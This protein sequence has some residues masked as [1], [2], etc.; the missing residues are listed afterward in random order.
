[1]LFAVQEFTSCGG[2]NLHK[3]QI[4]QFISTTN[5]RKAKFKLRYLHILTIDKTTKGFE[6]YDEK[7]AK[8]AIRE[9]NMAY[10][11]LKMITFKS[12]CF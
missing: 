5:M 8:S 9:R 7:D 11:L 3:N 2:K 4:S 1:V 10:S 6:C 12:S